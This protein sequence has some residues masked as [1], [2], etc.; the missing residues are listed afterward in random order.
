MRH[1]NGT[2]GV[3]LCLRRSLGAARAGASEVQACLRRPSAGRIHPLPPRCHPRRAG[4][5]GRRRPLHR[6]ARR[7][8]LD[9]RRRRRPSRYETTDRIH[10]WHRDPGSALRTQQPGRTSKRATP[11]STRCPSVNQPWDEGCSSLADSSPGP[12]AVSRPFEPT[13]GRNREVAGWLCHRVRRRHVGLH[14]WCPGLRVLRLAG[15]CLV[16]S[17]QPMPR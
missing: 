4:L 10:G 7:P 14:T 3:R 5:L 2:S 8:P 11:V 16:R 13:A 15:Q 17:K 9:A 12:Q 1:R 6:R